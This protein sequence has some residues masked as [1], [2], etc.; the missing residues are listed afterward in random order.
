MGFAKRQRGR[1]GV[2]RVGA[3]VLLLLLGAAAPAA[4]ADEV[5]WG[6]GLTL[7]TADGAHSFG[8]GAVL[9]PQFFW[10]ANDTTG[11]YADDVAFALRRMRLFLK[12]DL[13]EGRVAVVLSPGFDQ[14]EPRLYDAFADVRF[15]DGK[16][17]V[18]FGQWRR[19]Q[20]REWTSSL[21][22]LQFVDRSLAWT[23]FGASRDVG[24]ALHNGYEKAPEF[25]WFLGV[26]NGVSTVVPSVK[27]SVDETT[28]SV[29]LTSFTLSNTPKKM[30]PLVVARFAWNSVGG[31]GYSEMDLT[32][33]PPRYSVAVAGWFDFDGDDDGQ[34]TLGGSLEL[35]MKA[36]GLSLLAGAYATSTAEDQPFGTQD[37]QRVGFLVQGGYLIDKAFEPLVR[38]LWA[39]PYPMDSFA[40]ATQEAM[41]GFNWY[42]FGNA[43][44]WQM[45]FA[46]VRNDG[47]P[48]PNGDD[49]DDLR[50]RIQL[51]T[52]F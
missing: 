33:G 47:G 48:L 36:H 30:H 28:G 45:D 39:T 9:K 1:A 26:F 41:A 52:L 43:L 35:G 32:G 6:P 34:A 19:P 49:A 29:S 12:A 40:S 27:G 14:A 23:L 11:A 17:Q 24:I 13:F 15:L 20:L 18:R 46:W 50:L 42:Q 4:A 38:Y 16:L 5:L 21:T 8:V 3:L 22:R 31:Q 2:S 10:L 51:Q 37:L 44:K 25:E 7:Q